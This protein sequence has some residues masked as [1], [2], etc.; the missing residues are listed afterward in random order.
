LQLHE[1]HDGDP[2]FNN[3]VGMKQQHEDH[4]D[5]V[6]TI[7][8]YGPVDD[9]V[10]FSSSS[11]RDPASDEDQVTKIEFSMIN[12]GLPAVVTTFD[13]IGSQACHMQQLSPCSTSS[14]NQNLQLDERHDVDPCKGNQNL[15]VDEMGLFRAENVEAI[16][17]ML[18]SAMNNWDIS[19][20]EFILRY[21]MANKLTLPQEVEN[22][23]LSWWADAAQLCEFAERV[24][25]S[26]GELCD[27]IALAN[28]VELVG[29]SL[30]CCRVCTLLRHGENVR[31]KAEQSLSERWSREDW[32]DWWTP[33]LFDLHSEP[34]LADFATDFT[35]QLWDSPTDTFMDTWPY[36]RAAEL[37]D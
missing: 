18:Y 7:E 17:D 27:E 23:C 1:R 12:A 20:V 28:C 31:N 13:T 6:N 8:I 2:C 3:L 14:G 34:S 5:N 36:R 11:R 30:A 22:R 29:L 24:D 9:N 32:I 21:S 37:K 25:A 26:Y 16:L 33:K 15:Q 10:S 19:M 4:K 35:R